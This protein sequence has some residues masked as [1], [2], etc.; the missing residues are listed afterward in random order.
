MAATVRQHVPANLYRLLTIQFLATLESWKEGYV[1]AA[2]K[3]LYN[4]I[5]TQFQAGNRTYARY[6][7][8]VQSSGMGK[9]RM[10]DEL[11]KD[12]LVIP[13]NLRPPGSTGVHER[14]TH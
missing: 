14:P 13:I 3:V 9:S 10:I 5:S 2:H 7:A 4:S 6:Q 8:V 11:S 12:H 1:G